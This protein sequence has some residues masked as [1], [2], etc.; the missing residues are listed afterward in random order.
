MD[1][2][3]A[4]DRQEA[5]GLIRFERETQAAEARRER[6][7]RR[8]A[9]QSSRPRPFALAGRFLVRLGRALAGEVEAAD[10]GLGPDTARWPEA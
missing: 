10:L 3:R 9:G 2:W 4:V 6:L 5:L 1:P 7:G 8:G